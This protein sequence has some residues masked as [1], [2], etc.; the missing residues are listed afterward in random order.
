MSE[1]DEAKLADRWADVQRRVVDLGWFVPTSAGDALY[2]SVPELKG[3]ELSSMTFA[4]NPT[5][6]HF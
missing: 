6:W 3:I 2:Y 1:T 4:P 5:L